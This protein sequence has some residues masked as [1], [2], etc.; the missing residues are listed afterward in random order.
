LRAFDLDMNQHIH[1]EDH[2]L[3]PRAIAMEEQ[4]CAQRKPL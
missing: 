3:F 4:A 1:A 2:L